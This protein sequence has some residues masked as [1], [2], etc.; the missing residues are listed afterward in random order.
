MRPIG[1]H[2]DMITDD[3]LQRS[4]EQGSDFQTWAA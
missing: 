2:A 1:I 3:C 4:D